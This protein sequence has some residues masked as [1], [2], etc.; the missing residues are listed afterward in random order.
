MSSVLCT[1]HTLTNVVGHIGICVVWILK[2]CI[3]QYTVLSN[4]YWQGDQCYLI[5]EWCTPVWMNNHKYTHTHT[6][7]SFVF[8][9]ALLPLVSAGW[10]RA[11]SSVGHTNTTILLDKY[12]TSTYHPFLPFLSLNY[13]EMF[14]DPFHSKR[15][16]VVSWQ[17]SQ[18][19][20]VLVILRISL[21]WTNL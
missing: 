11:V 8:L 5:G 16:L 10:R 6:P 1:M 20:L 19:F 12:H 18:A 13:I 2:V 15:N 17:S 3:L 14:L 4:A 7:V 9:S 21:I